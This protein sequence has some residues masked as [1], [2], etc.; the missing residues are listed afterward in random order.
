MRNSE[1][2]ISDQ[3]P[4]DGKRPSPHSGYDRVPRRCL[5]P[6][7]KRVR[8]VRG[9]SGSQA[10][11]VPV[12]VRRQRPMQWAE[13]GVRCGDR[14]DAASG[15]TLVS[16]PRRASGS[17]LFRNIEAITEVGRVLLE[18]C[19]LVLF[20]VD[21]GAGLFTPFVPFEKLDEPAPHRL[22]IVLEPAVSR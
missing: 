13:T 22:I 18:K 16:R 1:F 6:L 10:P 7:A 4:T 12:Q 2:G 5:A 21:N 17:R 11:P 3:P 8:N 9:S 14:G 15:S 19:D 20:R